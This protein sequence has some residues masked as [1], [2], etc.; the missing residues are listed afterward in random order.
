MSRT[1]HALAAV[2]KT[3]VPF[4]VN[5]PEHLRAFH[6]LCIG[7]DPIKQHP[8]LRFQLDQPFLDVPSMM[9]HRVG[10]AYLTL[11]GN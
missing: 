11:K 1:T 5:N 4:D 2:Q 6:M 7:D 10:Q 3:Q 9:K 8:T